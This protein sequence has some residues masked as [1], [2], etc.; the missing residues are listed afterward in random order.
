MWKLEDWKY[1]MGEPYIKSEVE[2]VVYEGRCMIGEWFRLWRRNGMGWFNSVEWNE[3]GRHINV[4][5]CVYKL[6]QCKNSL[7][8]S[9]FFVF[10]ETLEIL[11]TEN[12]MRKRMFKYV[13]RLGMP[14]YIYVTHT[15]NQDLV[16]R[17]IIW[18][19]CC[20]RETIKKKRSECVNWNMYLNLKRAQ[21]MHCVSHFVRRSQ[22]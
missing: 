8:F 20:N 7:C 17:Y 10:I 6:E 12:I 13:W 14:I 16:V 4:E 1:Y 22:F 2:M 19:K 18:E 9:I 5:V 3:N 15:A 21:I 11:N